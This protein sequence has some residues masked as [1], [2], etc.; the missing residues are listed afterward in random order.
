MKKII[1]DAIEKEQSAANDIA[2]AEHKTKREQFA[3]M[4][5]QGF[6]STSNLTPDMTYF[7]ANAVEAADALL[8]ELDKE[9]S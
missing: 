2:A 8:K 7:A 9:Q 1:Q 5:M 4:A 3:A 6:L